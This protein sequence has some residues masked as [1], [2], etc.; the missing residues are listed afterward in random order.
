MVL[1]AYTKAEPEIIQFELKIQHNFHNLWETVTA[2]LLTQDNTVS[3]FLFAQAR[4]GES[5]VKPEI[6]LFN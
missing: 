5:V 6:V 3:N 4:V 1:E 2:V